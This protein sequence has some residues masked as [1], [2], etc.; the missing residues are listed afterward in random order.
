VIVAS[1]SPV[2]ILG[3]MPNSSDKSKIITKWS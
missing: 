3:L 2:M 1:G